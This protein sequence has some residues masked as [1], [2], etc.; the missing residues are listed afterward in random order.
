MCVLFIAEKYYNVLI[1]PCVD[2][3]LSGLQFLTIINKV[4]MNILRGVFLCTYALIYLGL[5]TGVEA[6]DLRTWVY[7][8]LLETGK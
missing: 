1:H 8:T 3:Y 5:Y 7:L 4:A 6:L 2:T